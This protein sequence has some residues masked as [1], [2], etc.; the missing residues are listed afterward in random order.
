[1]NDNKHPLQSEKWAEFREKT[2]VKVIN[3]ENIFITIH[4]IPHTKY[5]IGYV[6]KGPALNE[7]MLDDFFILGKKENCIFIQFEPNELAACQQ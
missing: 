4:S 5:K 2:G 1:M 6:P 3:F 7:K